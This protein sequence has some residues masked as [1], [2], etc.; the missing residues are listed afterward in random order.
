MK[1]AQERRGGRDQRFSCGQ[2]VGVCAAYLPTE[3]LPAFWQNWIYP[4]NPLRFMAGGYRGIMC[5]GQGF[6][7]ASSPALLVMVAVGAALVALKV[8][9]GARGKAS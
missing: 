8:E 1:R 7:N 5:M 4:W 3:F 6:W 2:V 9:L